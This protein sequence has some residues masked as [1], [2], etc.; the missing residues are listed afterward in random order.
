MNE[1]NV[2]AFKEA[3]ESTHGGKAEFRETVPVLE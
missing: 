1:I 2:N 3:V